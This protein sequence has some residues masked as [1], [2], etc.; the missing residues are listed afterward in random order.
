LN[1]T[2]GASLDSAKRAWWKLAAGQL[3]N[4]TNNSEQMQSI[5][6][7]FKLIKNHIK[8]GVQL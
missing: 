2:P 1:L 5:N 8:G 3:P 7:A 4:R 6:S